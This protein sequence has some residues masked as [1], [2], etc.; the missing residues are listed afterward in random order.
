MRIKNTTTASTGAKLLPCDTT[1]P[2]RFTGSRN[3]RTNSNT[4]GLVSRIISQQKVS[5]YMLSKLQMDTRFTPVCQLR[6]SC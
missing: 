3:R 4:S 5:V 6:S 2:E 1:M